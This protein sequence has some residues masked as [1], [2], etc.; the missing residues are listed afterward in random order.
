MANYNGVVT[1][2]YFKTKDNEQ[3]AEVL[4]KL[5][6]DESYEDNNGVFLGSYED[7]VSFDECKVVF[8]KSTKEYIGVSDDY[9]Y[10]LIIDEEIDDEELL[11]VP[12]ADY[13]QDMLLEGEVFQ[14]SFC[15]HEKL[16]YIVAGA[17]IITK[18]E[19]RHI[20]LNYEIE[21]AIDEMEK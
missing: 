10:N 15:G 20:N 11:E 2:Q 6:Y 7:G 16:R 1:S 18:K 17:I 19:I 12:L 5:G 4:F 3:V 21:K 14:M 9:D 13:L 8:R